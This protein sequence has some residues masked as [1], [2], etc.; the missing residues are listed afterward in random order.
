[1]S[2]TNLNTY[3][4]SFIAEGAR[5]TVSVKSLNETAALAEIADKIINSGVVTKRNNVHKVF[6]S[7]GVKTLT[8]RRDREGWFVSKAA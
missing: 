6:T 8:F 3:T 2:L 4:A 1:M 5:R 7:F